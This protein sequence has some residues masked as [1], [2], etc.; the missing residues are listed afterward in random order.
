MWIDDR[1][2]YV[3]VVEFQPSTW[4]KGSYLNVAANFLWNVLRHITF[5]VGDRVGDF[6]Q[7]ESEEQFGLEADRLAATA[8]AEVKRLR[9]LL[10]DVRS[11]TTAFPVEPQAPGRPAHWALYH[12]AIALGLVG[13]VNEASAI[14]TQLRVVHGSYRWETER[15]TVC[16]ELQEL[17]SDEQKYRNAIVHCINT[18][19][20][21]LGL[22]EVLDPLEADAH[23]DV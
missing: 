1:N 5:D 8:A 21:E 23:A 12:R 16:S 11:V 4:S 18:G 17:L 3:I 9:A 15:A 20:K 19:R 14:F 6:F 13:E 2:W 22:S 7:F 10:P